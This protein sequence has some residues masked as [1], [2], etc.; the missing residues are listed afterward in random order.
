MKAD[1]LVHGDRTGIC[2]S[3]VL[4]LDH[5]KRRKVYTERVSVLEA[6]RTAREGDP[7]THGDET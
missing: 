7:R 3:T 4:S 6:R 1:D 5:E 2:G